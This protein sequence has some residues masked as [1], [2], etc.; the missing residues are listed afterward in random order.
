MEIRWDIIIL[1]FLILLISYI[2]YYVIVSTVKCIPKY[3]CSEVNGTLETTKK[4][5]AYFP[6]QT[7]CGVY[8]YLSPEIKYSRAG[9][10]CVS[11][12]I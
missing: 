1:I 8:C 3:C 9:L 10:F 7:K 12:V 4:N 11:E 2:S 6:I 5:I